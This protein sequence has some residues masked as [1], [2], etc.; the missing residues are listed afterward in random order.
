M[1]KN[2]A[3]LI[4]QKESFCYLNPLDVKKAPQGFFNIELKATAESDCHPTPASK[5]HKHCID[6]PEFRQI[7]I[8][9]GLEK[10]ESFLV[11]APKPIEELDLDMYKSRRC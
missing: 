9:E 6:S 8:A 7:Q 10:P 4:S 1:S 5:S 3:N 2:K 11:Q